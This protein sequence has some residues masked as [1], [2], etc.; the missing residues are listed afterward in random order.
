MAN[1]EQNGGF[2][3]SGDHLFPHPDRFPVN[4]GKNPEAPKQIVFFA[5]N[6]SKPWGF[7][8]DLD[9]K[10]NHGVYQLVDT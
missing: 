3:A 9:L 6:F 5:Q 4:F 2:F 7:L 10:G 1:L 8:P